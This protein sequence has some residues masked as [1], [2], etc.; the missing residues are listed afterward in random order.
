MLVIIEN[1]LSLIQTLYNNI[2]YLI[3]KDSSTVQI[4]E[5]ENIADPS[6]SSTGIFDTH[7]IN[8]NANTNNTVIEEDVLIGFVTITLIWFIVA[9][10]IILSA[11]IITLIATNVSFHDDNT[12][13]IE[14]RDLEKQQSIPFVIEE[15]S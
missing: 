13:N 12:T 11:T 1:L 4:H 8:T 3:E 6:S 15:D 9:L 5:W 7:T 10:I 2:T 14:Y